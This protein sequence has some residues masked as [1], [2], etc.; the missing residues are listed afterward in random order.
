MSWRTLFFANPCKLNLDKDRLQIDKEGNKTHIPI[1]D[2]AVIILESH[3]ITL[4]NS[5]LSRLA[6][7]KTAIFSCGETH[8]PNGLFLPFANH[9]R[10]TQIANMQIGWSMPFKKRCWKDVV[11]IKIANQA[12]TLELCGR[13]NADKLKAMTSNIDSGDSK[14]VE[15][16][17]AMIHFFSLFDDFDRGMMCLQNSALNYGYA[18]LRG[19]VARSLVAYGFVTFLGLHHKNELNAYNL[20]DDLLEPLRPTVDKEVFMMFGHIPQ[21]ECD[22]KLSIEHKARLVDTLNSFCLIG[23]EQTNILNACEEIA[24]SL[25]RATRAKNHELLQ[26]PHIL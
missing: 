13:K 9:S 23:G 15:S 21:D 5:L 12:K 6:A 16:S 19:A 4:T 18:I 8:L 25:Q 17:A 26:L 2:I 11:K 24:K 20:A 10:L 1:D 7:N 3:Q 14:N 22:I